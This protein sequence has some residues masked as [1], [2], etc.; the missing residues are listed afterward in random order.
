MGFVKKA[1]SGVTKMVGAGGAYNFDPNAANLTPEQ[2]QRLAQDYAMQKQ[3]VSGFNPLIS[4]LSRTAQGKGPSLITRQLR[5]AT[6][7][8]IKQQ[9]GIAASGRGVNPALALRT[10]SQNIGDINQEAAFQASQA[11]LAE[12]QA[13]REAEMAARSTQ[14]QLLSGM[15]GQSYQE[16]EGGRGSRMDLEKM[17]GGAYE[18]SQKRRGEFVSN[19]GQGMAAVG[20]MSDKNVKKDIKMSDKEIQSFLDGMKNYSFKYKGDK[21][22]NYGVMAQDL[23]KSDAGEN[24]V[25]ET[26]EGKMINF[27]KGLSTMLAGQAQ[28]NKRLKKLEGKKDAS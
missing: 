20:I 27:A 6:N 9:M 25:E 4:S 1:V 14:G 2:Q 24:M 13:A 15:R 10:A 16:A 8:N 19:M 26:P 7:R 12:I 11:R 23:E 18:G 17:R 5:D 22:T 21:E 3:S 28:L